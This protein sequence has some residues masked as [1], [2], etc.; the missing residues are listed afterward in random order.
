MYHTTACPITAPN[1]AINTIFKLLQRPKASASGV[2]EVVPARFMLVNTGLSSS[3]MRIQSE[4]IKSSSEAR[5]GMRQPH[6]LKASS[7]MPVR[8]PITTSS[9]ANKP[10]V[11]VVWIQL[12]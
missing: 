6:A 2:F 11:A 5:N 12:V 9:A 4:T 10:S 8:V 3:F 1:S 7:P